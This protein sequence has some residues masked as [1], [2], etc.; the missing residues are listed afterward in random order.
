MWF[1]WFLVFAALACTGVARADEF[2]LFAP[3]SGFSL[4]ESTYPPPPGGPFPYSQT[5]G[6][7]QWSVGPWGSPGGRMPPFEVTQDGQGNS[8]FTTHSAGAGVSVIQGLAG[9]TLDLEQDGQQLA[10]NDAAGRPKEFDLFAEPNGA[11]VKSPRLAGLFPAGFNNPSLSTLSHLHLS[12]T[13]TM[14]ESLAVSRKHCQANFAN[15][16]FSVILINNV[17][18]PRQVFFYQLLFSRF[19]GADLTI[20]LNSCHIEKKRIEQYS[21]RNPYGANDFL[22][23]LGMAWLEN[24]RQTNIQADLLPRLKQAIS[25]GPAGLDKDITHWYI[26]SV[27]LGQSIYGDLALHSSWSKISLLAETN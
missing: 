18:K 17:S 11:R 27:Y 2:P 26:G 23:L 6:A 24:G 13:V 19:C 4:L 8:I 14:Q 25:S 10:C 7:L 22:P 3:M 9:T 12:A 15:T 16:Q 1:F 5:D 20:K 21:I